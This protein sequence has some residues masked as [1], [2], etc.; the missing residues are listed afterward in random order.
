MSVNYDIE[1]DWKASLKDYRGQV[2]EVIQ[3]MPKADYNRRN[4]FSQAFLRPVVK[5]KTNLLS[6]SDITKIVKTT[7]R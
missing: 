6:Q 3:E 7:I 2:N 4:K 1:Q 5:K